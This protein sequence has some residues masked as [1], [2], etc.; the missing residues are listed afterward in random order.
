MATGS[1]A[2]V[3]GGIHGEIMV[4]GRWVRCGEVYGTMVEVNC[5][6]EVS[7]SQ[8]LEVL[9]KYFGSEHVAKWSR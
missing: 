2:A 5:E 6:V 3:G 1:S 7:T 8:K 9:W 4:G